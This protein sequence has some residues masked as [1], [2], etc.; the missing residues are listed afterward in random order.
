MLG[1]LR[2]KSRAH[3]TSLA[4]LRGIIEGNMGNWY[5]YKVVSPFLPDFLYIF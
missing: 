4:D 5:S 2:S 1:G 3:I